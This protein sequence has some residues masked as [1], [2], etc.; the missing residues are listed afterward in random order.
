MLL[1]ASSCAQST[2]RLMPKS[3]PLFNDTKL[4][5]K[6]EFWVKQ[7]I[8]ALLPYQVKEDRGGLCPGK[9]CPNLGEFGE[10]FYSNGLRVGL[11]IR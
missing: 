4:I 9:L 3:R 1:K 2:E 6:T 5:S 10:E 11:L 7:K 8:I